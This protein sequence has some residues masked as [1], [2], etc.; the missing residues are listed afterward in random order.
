MR[1]VFARLLLTFIIIILAILLLSGF[2]IAQTYSNDY[3][4]GRYEELRQEGERINELTA[5][6]VFGTLPQY[7]YN[8]E[9]FA[10]SSR[11]GCV[12]WLTN[13]SGNKASIFYGIG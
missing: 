13:L 7:V 3:I 6:A 2:L 4:Q 9:M 10:T 5:Q 12:V 1:T 8:V 11:Y